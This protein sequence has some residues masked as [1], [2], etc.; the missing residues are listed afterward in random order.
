MPFLFV[1]QVLQRCARQPT[2]TVLPPAEANA[3]ANP[4]SISCRTFCLCKRGLFLSIRV[5][6][7]FLQCRATPNPTNTLLFAGDTTSTRSNAT[8]TLFLFARQ[9]LQHAQP[10]LPTPASTYNRKAM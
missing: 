8:A 9:T 5:A 7:S 4:T 1:G 6:L 3:T 10:T 2:N